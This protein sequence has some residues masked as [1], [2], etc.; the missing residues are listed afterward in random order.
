MFEY[1]IHTSITEMV[2]FILRSGSI[3]YTYKSGSRAKRGIQIHQMLQQKHYKEALLNGFSYEE[4]YTLLADISYK[5]ISYEIEGRADGIVAT[6]DKVYIEEIKSTAKA[7]DEITE[8]KEVHMAQA[9]CYGYLYCLL[10]KLKQ[11]VINLTYCNI[12]TLETKVFKKEMKLEELKAYFYGII[13][14]LYYWNE[15]E[16]KNAEKRNKS[17][18]EMSFPFGDFRKGQRDFSVAVYKTLHSSKKLFAQAPTGTGKTIATLF[19]AIKYL[20]EIKTST[21]KIFYLTAKNI[22]RGIGEDCIRAMADN[23]LEIKSIVLSAKEKTCLCEENSA[24]SAE[25]CPYANGHY[26]RVNSAL[27]ELLEENQQINLETLLSY[28]EKFKVC[29]FE[30]GLD[31]SLFVDVIICD[32][33]YAYDP[34]ARLKRFFEEKKGDYIALVDEA[35]NLVDRAREMFSAE[36]SKNAVYEV[37]SLLPFVHTHIFKTLDK[38]NSFFVN[39]LSRLNYTEEA[40]VKKNAPEELINLL[41]AFIYDADLWLRGNTKNEAYEKLLQLY[42]TVQDFLRISEL[43]D[44][45]FCTMLKREENDAII[46]LRCLDPSASLKANEKAFKSSIFFS[47]TLTPLNYFIDVLGGEK[48][49]NYMAIQCH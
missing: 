36:L 19:P 13:D 2:E 5:S 43:Y 39:E 49:D 6:K 16:L 34:K 8:Y 4:E 24:C 9:I 42:F 29:P 20:P 46:S 31:A 44:N 11:A 30:L 21:G 26:D 47:A 40:L 1:K 12:E 48:S 35:H 3:D 18:T 23:G 32:Y 14:K 7:P 15:M 45:S 37:L 28:A 27:W 38:I 17:I 25:L 22:T 33:N 41:G 10:K